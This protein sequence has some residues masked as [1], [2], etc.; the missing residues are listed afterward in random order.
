MRDILPPPPR[1]VHRHFRCFR[2]VDPVRK[3]WWIPPHWSRFL[4]R[5]GQIGNDPHALFFNSQRRD[6]GEG[7]RLHQTNTGCKGLCA[8]PMSEVNRGAGANPSGVHDHSR[9]MPR[10]GAGLLTIGASLLGRKAK[11]ELKRG[12]PL[13]GWRRPAIQLRVKV[14][15]KSGPPVCSFRIHV[16]RF[17]LFFVGEWL[18]RGQLLLQNGSVG[19]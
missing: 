6:F 11:V 16:K 1:R 17:Q 2:M 15:N 18:L 12:H 8:A 10:T 3:A 19:V 14:R 4:G 7:R 13:L 5:R 9:K